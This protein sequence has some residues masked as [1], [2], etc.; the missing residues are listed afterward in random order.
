VIGRLA[1]A[2]RKEAALDYVADEGGNVAC[3]P[4]VTLPERSNE[5]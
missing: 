1:L 4:A 5:W 2:I 3:F